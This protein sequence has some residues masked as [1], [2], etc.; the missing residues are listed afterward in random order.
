MS[1]QKNFMSSYLSK[2]VC[3]LCILLIYFSC[4]D[5]EVNCTNALPE[6]NWFDLGFF[7][8]QEQPLIGTVYQQET[9]RL[10][11]SE[12][13]IFLATN[14][15]GD[16]TRLQVRYNDIVPRNTYFIELSSTDIDTLNF[17]F[18][19]TQGPCFPNYDLQEVIYNGQSYTIEN[20]SRVDLIK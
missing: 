18:E 3:F 1:N 16:S 12:N 15:F 4:D 20:T 2:L 14:P 13:E 11:N 17:S 6:P 10:Y 9:F 19:V 8:V 7:N 5:K